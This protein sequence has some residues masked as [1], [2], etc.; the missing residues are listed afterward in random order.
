MGLSR[1]P[2]LRLGFAGTPEFAAVILEALFERHEVAVVYSQPPRPTGRGRKIT[3]SAVETLARSRGIEVRMP[4]SLRGEAAA[5]VA[6]RLDAIIVAAYGLIL[7]ASVLRATRYGCINV[8]ASLLP[9]WRGAAPIERAMMAGDHTTGVSIMQMD[10]GL[11]TGP[12]LGYAACAILPND[13]GD[14][15]RE[16]LAKVGAKALLDCLD[17]LTDLVA[18]PQ[19]TEGATYAA[20]LAP[21]DSALRWRDTAVELANRIRALNSRQPAFG[22]CNGERIRLLLAEPIEEASAAPPG[23]VIGIDRGGLIVACGSGRLRVTRVALTRGKGK[24]MD[25]ASLVNG[26]TELIRPGQTFATSP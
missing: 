4:K 25:I 14:S 18:T 10:E 8:H 22:F 9:R 13:T 20:K 7:P 16:R 6:D 1:T 19:P 2:R 11:D 3:S 17:R 24:P 5:L 23:T 12:V 21:A 15:L 26:Y